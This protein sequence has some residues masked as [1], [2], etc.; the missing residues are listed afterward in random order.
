MSIVAFYGS[1]TGPRLIDYPRS[2]FVIDALLLIFF[3]GGIRLARRITGG[4]TAAAASGACCLRRRR[5]RR[6][7]RA[8]HAQHGLRV[9]ADR[10]H[11]RRSGQGR[12]ADPRR[13]GARHAAELPQIMATENGRR[14]CWSRCRCGARAIRAIVGA[15]EP[16]KVPITTLPN[17]RDLLNG[18]RDGEP[19]PQSVDRGPAA[20]RAGRPRPSRSRDLDRGPAGAGH[21]RGR[22]DRIGAVPSDRALAP[23][24][25]VLFERYENSLYAI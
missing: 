2:V 4:V 15:L 18:Q 22:L 1:C 8:R 6:D 10:L 14:W 9:R 16:F 5:R 24:A 25:L 23:A 12:A 7:D 21:R 20:A 19:D 3:M 17:L 13:P 11:R